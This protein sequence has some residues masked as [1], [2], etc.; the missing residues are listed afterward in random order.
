MDNSMKQNLWNI[1]ANHKTQ[2][3]S[4][5]QILKMDKELNITI[6][7]IK[8][9]GN[10]V[11]KY[12]WWDE[13]N[14]TYKLNEFDPVTQADLESE[15][16]INQ[17]IRNNFPNDKILSE[18]TEYGLTDFSGRVRMIDPLDWTKDFVWQW[19]RYSIMIGLCIDWVPELWVVL[20]PT[21]WDLYYAKRGKG[22][23]LI[24][25]KWEFKKLE[26]SKIKQ[27]EESICFSKSKFSEDRPINKKIEDRLPFNKIADWWSLG[28][29]LWEIASWTWECYIL[30]ND[31]ACK[32]DSCAPQ[33][34]LE[35]AWGMVTDVF[36]DKIDYLTWTKKLS[37]LL[38][39]TNW[40]I[41][42]EVIA[43]T[44]EIFKK[45]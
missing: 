40:E 13:L 8:E 17:I 37:N 19:D 36:W 6:E 27:I 35:E 38:V 23:Y 43:S 3:E 24:N 1:I 25:N 4:L 12:Y 29:V 7:A 16:Y 9:A 28:V 10:I 11:L 44:K 21:W 20:A 33:I 26:V 41:H 15:K 39:A 2:D 45:E 31:K 34:I 30:T 42:K 32:R 22:S 14:T 5:A 18:E